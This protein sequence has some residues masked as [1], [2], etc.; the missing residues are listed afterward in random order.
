MDYHGSTYE[1]K[2]DSDA[3]RTD[4]LLELILIRISHTSDEHSRIDSGKGRSRSIG[5]SLLASLP[6]YREHAIPTVH[7]SQ[8]LCDPRPSFLLLL[9]GSRTLVDSSGRSG[10]SSEQDGFD[11]PLQFFGPTG[12]GHQPIISRFSVSRLFR[13]DG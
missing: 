3:L 7:F 1:D 13:G 5:K 12:P 9:L 10:G 11:P 6:E 8:N 2:N 4:L